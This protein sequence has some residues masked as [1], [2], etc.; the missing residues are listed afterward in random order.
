MS[1]EPITPD[2]LELSPELKHTPNKWDPNR[3]LAPYDKTEH[4]KK[5]H[6]VSHR[7]KLQA[8]EQAI[9][10]RG[11][12]YS[13][14]EVLKKIDRRDVTLVS[15]MKNDETF[16]ERWMAADPRGVKWKTFDGTFAEFSDVCLGKPLPDHSKPWVEALEDESIETLCILVPPY[17]A[18]SSIVSINWAA[19][20]LARDR[21]KRLC[22][23]SRTQTY[24][25]KLVR[26]VGQILTDVSL[27][28]GMRAYKPFKSE[29]D[30]NADAWRQDYLYVLG[31]GSEFHSPSLEAKGIG[32]QIY[33]DRFHEVCL[34]DVCDVKS[35]TENKRETDISIIRQDML[36]RLPHTGGKLVYVG[37]RVGHPDVPS[38]LIE[39]DF[40]DVVIKQPAIDEENRPLWP[41]AWP[42]AKLQKQAK[43]VGPRLWQLQYQ[44]TPSL[45][46]HATFPHHLVEEAKD[47]TY[48]IEHASQ[49]L[50]TRNLTKVM[51]FDPAL[52]GYAV[53]FL[54]GLETKAPYRRFVLDIWREKDLHSELPDF[55]VEAIRAWKPSRAVIEQ[56][57]F[58]RF[59]T[60]LPWVSDAIRAEGCY[61]QP[62]QTTRN[63]HDPN[64]GVTSLVRMFEEHTI[65]IPWGSQQTMA[66][67][68]PFIEELEAW[69]PD[70]K[71]LLSDQV[72]AFWMADL[73]CRKLIPDLI[74]F[75][76]HKKSTMPRRLAA[77]RWGIVDRSNPTQRETQ[78]VTYPSRRK[79]YA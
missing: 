20:Q 14:A 78:A 62:H 69:E 1:D 19:Y 7:E 74:P 15:W 67:M 36:S 45:N 46:E 10:Y 43:R 50:A 70:N 63:K 3:L 48:T 44:Q 21:T 6:K 58:Q 37:T 16:R 2:E 33:G 13:R 61:A 77:Q 30:D 42:L 32:S 11:Q 8:M 34:D 18:K 23:L 72:M 68:R 65:S 76:V 64:M 22:R 47:E 35:N 4:M 25:R 73:G 40:F 79:R 51:G 54:L 38:I 28:P 71:D 41:K 29:A 75:G 27:Y 53:A 55:L 9:S 57:N 66:R 52:A 59:L 17:H 5:F 24:A 12:G 56:N 49:R 39:E 31:A 60:E 26:S